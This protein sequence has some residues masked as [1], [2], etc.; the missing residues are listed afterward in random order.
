MLHNA[1]HG[2]RCPSV[3][4]KRTNQRDISEHILEWTCFLFMTDLHTTNCHITL[5][6]D[7]SIPLVK[8]EGKVLG[9]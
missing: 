4:Y 9:K 5:N 2:M 6:F 3:H 1:S 8:H 7:S